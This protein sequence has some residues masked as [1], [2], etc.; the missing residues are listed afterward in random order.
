MRDVPRIRMTD[1]G[2]LAT[3]HLLQLG[4]RAKYVLSEPNI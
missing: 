2:H 3:C 1:D 4:S